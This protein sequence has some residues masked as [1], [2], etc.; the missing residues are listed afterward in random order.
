V[1]SRDDTPIEAPYNRDLNA[2]E[3]A[4]AAVERPGDFFVRGTLETPMPRVEIDGVGVIAFP[5]GQCYAASP[6]LLVFEVGQ[7]FQEPQVVGN[8][9]VE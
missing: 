7:S 6:Y 3:E 4:L 9:S 5:C 8:S 1:D 2:L